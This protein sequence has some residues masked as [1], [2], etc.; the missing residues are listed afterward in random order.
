[1]NGYLIVKYLHIVAVILM[2]G[3]VFAR[4]LVRGAARKSDDVK[5]AA[6]FT[7]MARRLDSIMVI[8]GGNATLVLGVILALIAGFPIL[9]SYCLISHLIGLRLGTGRLLKGRRS[10][11]EASKPCSL[12]AQQG[13]QE[14]PT[15]YKPFIPDFSAI[16]LQ[17]SV[18]F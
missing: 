18:T 8:P 17:K 9:T 1:M 5:L 10:F 4:Q 3:G 12:G 13:S 15:R 6:S 14:N 16:S 2:I 11:T 7:Q